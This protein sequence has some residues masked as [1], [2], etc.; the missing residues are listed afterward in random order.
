MEASVLPKPLL[1]N[2]LPAIFAGDLLPELTSPQRQLRA[3]PFVN[4][5]VLLAVAL[6]RRF[7]SRPILVRPLC[8]PTEPASGSL[9]NDVLREMP[10]S[11]FEGEIPRKTVLLVLAAEGSAHALAKLRS[12]P[13][14][15]PEA[16]LL[17]EAME[18][19]LGGTNR[20]QRHRQIPGWKKGREP[21]LLRHACCV[22]S[23]VPGA[24]RPPHLPALNLTLMLSIHVES[25][26]P[27]TSCRL[28]DEG[29]VRP[30]SQRNS[31]V[32]DE[33]ALAGDADANMALFVTVQAYQNAFG[34]EK[35]VATH[36]AN[37]SLCNAFL[38][39]A[40]VCFLPFPLALSLALQFP[41]LALLA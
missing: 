21:S 23:G 8:G 6:G 29:E 1:H 20:R 15:V 38:E 13:S 5:D 35:D 4:A 34:R 22:D 41:A 9:R 25:T 16:H 26:G 33:V 39:A 37:H 14:G 3:I 31:G 11:F 24:E 32:E 36:R 7:E 28:E 19:A 40:A 27:A 17:D 18:A 2:K 30:A 12:R 10:R